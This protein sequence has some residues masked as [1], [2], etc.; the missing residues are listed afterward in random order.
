MNGP[1]SD[2][3]RGHEV[4]EIL[5]GD[6]GAEQSGRLA[7]HL[8]KGSFDPVSDED[9]SHGGIE[10]LAWYQS[11]H[12]ASQE[13]SPQRPGIYVRAAGVLT[14]ASELQRRVLEEEPQWSIDS[15][16][17]VRLS[18][19]LLVAHERYHEHI[20]WLSELVAEGQ[21]AAGQRDPYGATRMSS[22]VA[23]EALATRAMIVALSA[24]L[25][26]E[27]NL[28]RSELVV[29]QIATTSALHEFILDSCPAEYRDG[30]NMTLDDGTAVADA[31]LK[32]AS[33]LTADPEQKPVL[34]S[35]AARSLPLDPRATV[36]LIDDL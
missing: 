9:L 10:A 3:S 7:A 14:L 15:A 30:V 27:M 6:L 33:D 13:G 12:G 1:E 29:R 24:A 5:G 17:L 21:G 34:A 20:E 31:T 2:P 11:R 16:V 4:T 18:F 32:I 8:D 22:H 23:E 26:E 25:A 19:E 35:L 36:N 28:R